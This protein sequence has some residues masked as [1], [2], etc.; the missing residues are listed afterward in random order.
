MQAALITKIDTESL[1]QNTIW[2][3][4]SIL[5]DPRVKDNQ[6]FQFITLLSLSSVLLFVEQTISKLL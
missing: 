2:R 6:K 3:H 5:K 4:F 1:F